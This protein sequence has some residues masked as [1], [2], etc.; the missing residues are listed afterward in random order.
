MKRTALLLALA[1]CGT[2]SPLESHYNRGVEYYDQG[3]LA[4]AVREYRLAVDE[5]PDNPRAHYNL[6][7]AYHDLE[8]RDDAAAEYL[9][10]LKL[11]P[12]NARALVSL[13]SLRADEG[14][15]EEAVTLLDRAI[16]ADRHSAFPQEA[17][18]AWFER[19]GDLDRALQAYRAAAAIEPG[20]PAAHAGIGR[21]LS[22]RGAYQDAVAEYDR[23]VAA[24]GSDIAVLIGASE[25]REKVGDLKAAMLLLERALVNVKDRAALWIRLA[26][27]YESQDRL[28]DA[29][30]SLWEARAVEP[31]NAEVGP[32][33]KALY[34]KLSAK[35]R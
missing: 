2:Y 24:D 28:E 31:A 17:R 19:K 21:I 33:L 1:G 13:A 5:S 15:E 16:L 22:K 9:K 25:A 34:D 3:K 27:L 4:D 32:R 29:V 18:G 12:D 10:V 8:R 6:A 23:A 35:E 7:V 11:R 14:K 20:S 30:A 26:K